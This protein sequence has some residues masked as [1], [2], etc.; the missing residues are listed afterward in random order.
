MFCFSVHFGVLQVSKVSPF[1]KMPEGLVCVGVLTIR[2]MYDNLLI[3]CS[4]VTVCIRPKHQAQWFVT[5][6][7][8]IPITHQHNRHHWSSLRAIIPARGSNS[9]SNKVLVLSRKS[10]KYE[11]LFELSTHVNLNQHISRNLAN[12]RLHSKHL[13]QR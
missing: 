1:L 12:G 10:S 6:R 9:V 5:H 7:I 4:K 13:R 11:E 2:K 8:T 3:R